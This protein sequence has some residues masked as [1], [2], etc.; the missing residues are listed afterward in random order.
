M[1]IPALHAFNDMQ[2][3]D[4]LDMQARLIGEQP[5]LIWE[6]FEG[7]S[8]R[9]TF[10]EFSK[11]T[12]KLA[13]GIQAQ[14]IKRGDFVLIHLDNCP[15]FL[16]AWAACAR[17]GA[18]AVTTNTRSVGDEI[19]Y[20]ADNCG[21]VAAITQPKYAE[22]LRDNC[23][24]LQWIAVTST[25]NDGSAASADLSSF[26][27]FEDLFADPEG[28][29]ATR[30]DP[31]DPLCV[32]YTSGTTSRPKG[33]VWTHA[34]GLWAARATAF[35]EGLTPDDIHQCF[36]PLFH[37]NAISN[38]F[39][40]SLQVGATLVLQPR[41]S[42][43]RFWPV[44]IKHQCTWC[45]LVPF[46]IAAIGDLDIPDHNFR[47]WG[48]GISMP[49]L[50]KKFGVKTVGWWG[51]TETTTV[52]IV[53]SPYLENTP[54]MLGRPSPFYEIS[55]VNA[56]GGPVAPGETGD[57]KIK[58]IPSLTLFHHYLNNPGATA[59]S[60]DEEGFFLTGDR[61]TLQKDGSIRFADRSKDML[62]VGGENVAASEVERVIMGVPGVREVAVVAR[63]DKFLNEIPVAFVIPGPNADNIEQEIAAACET[64]LADFK[65]PREVRIVDELP[66]AT[67]NKIAKAELRTLLEKE[68]SVTA[69]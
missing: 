20:F 11:E 43:S 42:A 61:C 46:C 23:P 4:L 26:K 32:M 53:T 50:D 25:E 34:N 6:P 47:Y 37:M 66:R 39:L 52:G 64:A 62:K 63:P 55:I 28:F 29:S 59:E 8:Q 30:A 18:V 24:G 7:K 17:I 27:S 12:I 67:L 15:D 22:L 57:L 9:W 65:R 44:A 69:A 5:F 10:A 58:G 19:N 13:A 21:A 51:M 54:M 60:F 38:S 40:A 41:F 16:F 49:A 3:P 31:F 1:N 48:Y 2:L 68:V 36:L 56:G 45:S 35:H 14:G 33:V